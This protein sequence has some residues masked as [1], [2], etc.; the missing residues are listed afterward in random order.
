M[1][2]ED[3]LFGLWDYGSLF[4]VLA[5]DLGEVGSEDVV[6]VVGTNVDCGFWEAIPLEIMQFV[7]G[8]CV[9]QAFLCFGVCDVDGVD[10]FYCGV[11]YGFQAEWVLVWAGV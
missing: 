5:E 10:Y 4:M 3:T 8:L 9:L 2:F 11:R 1:G 6:G 7:R